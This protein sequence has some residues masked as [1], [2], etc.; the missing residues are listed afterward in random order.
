MTIFRFPIAVA[1]Y[2][3]KWGRDAAIRYAMD[4]ALGKRPTYDEAKGFV[5]LATYQAHEYYRQ[6]ALNKDD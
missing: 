3:A 5:N 1:H 6:K 2:A 4:F